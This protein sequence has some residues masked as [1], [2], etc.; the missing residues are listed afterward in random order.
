ML[1][2]NRK[3]ENLCDDDFTTIIRQKGIDM[4]HEID[5]TSMALKNQANIFVL[6]TDDAHFVSAPMLA[7][8]E[9]CKV[10]LDPMNQKVSSDLFEHI[11][12]LTL[13][14]PSLTK[15]TKNSMKK[16]NHFS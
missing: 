11:D 8:C 15:N 14:L 5:M 9:G 1:Q 2:D 7:L 3:F 12:G 16:I 4:P 13:G 6:A 10:I